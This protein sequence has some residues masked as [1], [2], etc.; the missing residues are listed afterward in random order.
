MTVAATTEQVI[1]FRL[2]A[3]HLAERVAPEGLL[4]AAGA[5]AVQDSPPGSALLALH[6][7]VRD[8]TPEVMAAAVEEDKTLT[9]TWSMR[10]APFVVPTTDASVFTTGML[11]P[12]EEG[13]RH[14]VLGVEQSLDELGMNLTEVVDL[15]GEEIG[16]VLSGRRL[17][18]NEL[19]AELADRIGSRLTKAQRA[20]WQQQGHHAKGQPTGEAV[21]HFSL[22]ILALQQVVCFAPRADNT[23]PFVLVEE[24]LD[25]IPA[26]PPEAARAELV[27]RY[28]RCH[29]P[30][31][32]ADFASWVGVRAG[33]ADPWWSL[34]EEEMT[35]VDTGSS[36][37]ILTEDRD[38]LHSTPTPTG[39]RLLPPG[40][41]YTQMRDRETI[42]A[43]EHHRALWTTVGSPGAVLVDGEVVGTWRPRK[44]G[45]RLSVTIAPFNS[46]R[47][48][49][50][51]SIKD[52]VEQ[53]APLRGASA[54]DVHVD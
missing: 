40:D 9:R 53:I 29:G 47:R 38:A 3:H 43:R 49:D 15:A 37:W 41:P 52:E 20:V 36:G 23:A 21:V 34:V 2:A 50:Q 48:R 39:V 19:G 42:V 26:M 11:P 28:L 12:T 51:R 16:E 10:G 6:A 1:A 54:V 31:T 18:I 25:D 8:L 33:D 14:L 4:D 32:R 7:R 13:R 45:K 22:R 35:E 30:S 46:L 5:C 17:A 44:K 27:R 24:W